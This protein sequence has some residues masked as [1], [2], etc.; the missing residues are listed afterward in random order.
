[1]IRE[2]TELEKA[3]LSGGCFQNRILFEGV[4]RELGKKG[5]AVYI[6]RNLPPN[7]GCIA[8]AKPLL[9]HHV[10]KR[11]ERIEMHNIND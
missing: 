8:S 1:M 9:P 4:T 10:F 11:P 2:R 3:V 5:F 6:H 7:D